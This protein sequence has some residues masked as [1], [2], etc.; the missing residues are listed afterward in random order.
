MENS[1][2]IKNLVL[3]IVREDD[4]NAFKEFY[5]LFFSK[6]FAFAISITKNRATAEEVVADVFTGLWQQRHLLQK[7]DNISAY[8]MISVRNRA[9]YYLKKQKSDFRPDSD[10]DLIPESEEQTPY[11]LMERSELLALLDNAVNSLPPRCKMIFYLVKEEGLSHKEVAE[12]LDISRRTVN[13]QMV[14]AVK[15]IADFLRKK[16]K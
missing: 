10:F 14:L 13:A 12:I 8:V 1:G 4:H 16:Q 9:R 6:A 2:L 5:D 3:K 7:V 11:Q 15:K